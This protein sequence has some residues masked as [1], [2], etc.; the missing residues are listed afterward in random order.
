MARTKEPKLD[1]EFMNLLPRQT[2]E[3]RA[4]LRES[5]I[6]EG[7]REPLII[8]KEKGILVDGYNRYDVV[9]LLGVE[10]KKVKCKYVVKSFKD[11][12]EVIEWIVANQL[13]R[14]NLTDEKRAYFIGK[15]YLAKKLPAGGVVPFG[16]NDQKVD[17]AAAMAEK[18]GVSEK[19]IRRNA[20]YAKGVDA[21]PIKDEILGGTSGLSKQDVIDVGSQFCDECSRDG[22]AKGCK[23]CAKKQAKGTTTTTAKGP[24]SGGVL[25]NWKKYSTD[26]GVIIRGPDAIK[27]GY[28]SEVKAAADFQFSPD[29]TRFIRSGEGNDLDKAYRLL[30]QF[31][32]LVAAMQKRLTK[33]E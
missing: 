7:V 3:E 17:T 10:K 5:I 20:E 33:G 13:G 24:K 9:H 21:S 14:R 12:D 15:E 26:L 27:A 19:T 2:K 30:E 23:K 6:K 28:P 18:Y 22:P 16:K 32:R 29:F 11:R 31:A 8:W 4:F 25:F 1:D